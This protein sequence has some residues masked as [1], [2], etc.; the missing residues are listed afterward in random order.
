MRKVAFLVCF[1]LLSL[2]SCRKELE[3]PS[4]DT[5]I[6][7]P[8]VNASLDITNILPDSIL[9]VNL[10]S[11]LKIAYSNDIYKLSMY[12]LF[13]IPD[14][15]IH[16]GYTIPFPV[17]LNPGD[18]VINNNSTET[19]YALQ[20]VELR[21]ATIK[22]GY[23]R[24]T[25]KSYI[26]EVTDFVYSIPSA[27]LNNIPFSINISVP[28]A[29]GSSPGIFTKVYDLSGYTFNLTGISN[30]K[31]NTLYT[32]LTASISPSGQSVLV[33][34]SDSLIIDNIFYDI[35]PY[36]AKGYFGQ[37]IFNVGPSQSAFTMFNR[38]VDGSV[39]LEDINFNLTIEN[40]I[41]MDARVF[42]NN[43]SS[44]NTRTGNTVNLN[45]SIIGS[46]INVNRATES[47]GNVFSTYATF[48]LTVSNSNIKNMIENLPDQFGY[49]ME[50]NTNPLGN[51]SGSNDF[52]YS[53]KLLNARLDMEIPL[54][55]IASNLIL[56]DTFNLSLSNNNSIQNIH[57]G[58]VTLF[59]NNGFPFD[60]AMQFYLLDDND[61]VADSL[62]GYANTI[63]E[64]PINQSN[65]VIAKKLTKI[66]V[67]LSESRMDL[68]YKSKKILLKIKFNT[69]NQPQYMK[70]YSDYTI[71]IKLVGDFNYTIQLQ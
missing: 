28:A 39:D 17:T 22:S 46:P 12:T 35:V 42:I 58:T 37:N 63:D 41:G 19:T 1:I 68:L 44:I 32:T 24:Y 69:S 52:I 27:K 10:D 26:K 66:V 57:S 20:G 45:N 3:K 55:F 36:Y 2:F 40:P 61:V 50:V 62:L 47:G 65:R 23:V 54:S 9:Q 43:L 5:E 64:A 70:I 67:P 56:A 49:I 14:T 18:V 13:K 7:A 6:L 4:W 59:A 25:I 21:T 33:N 60:A 11:S 34:P 51:V 53:D 16:N 15:A 38:I 30:T 8:L 71:D 31:V 29:V 48:P